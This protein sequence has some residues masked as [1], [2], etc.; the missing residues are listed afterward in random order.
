MPRHSAALE[1]ATPQAI[2]R[3]ALALIDEE[4]PQALNLRALARRLGV[5]HTTI[6]RRCGSTLDGLIDLCT[7]HLAARL[8]DIAPG[9]DW[10]R[11]TEE[12]F[13]RLYELLA[14]HPGL[15]TLRGARPWLSPTLLER[16][17]EPQVAAN[18]AVGMPPE[19][20]MAVYRQMYLFTLGAAGFVDH[21]DPR[22]A[23]AVSRRALAAL[24]PDR[25]PALTGHLD[26]ML[27][28]LADHAVHRD[29]LRALIRAADPRRAA[30]G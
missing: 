2:A 24:D 17:V 26:A 28:P 22:E 25:F 5:S 27:P 15:V 16:L 18:I 21:R 9:T 19:R 10:A 3:A 11:G 4:G 20:A 1:R 12:R 30:S 14:R 7:D 13:T 23:M 8:P 29:G 6:H